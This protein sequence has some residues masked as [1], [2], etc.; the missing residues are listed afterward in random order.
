M[1]T[2]STSTTELDRPRFFIDGRWANPVG[3]EVYT[4]LEAATGEPLGRAALGSPADIDAAVTAARRALD[5]GPW[6]RSTPSERAAVMRRFAAALAKRA[7]ATS[8]LVSQENGMPLWL[9]TSFNGAAPVG[10]L[11]RY[12]DWAETVLFEETRASASG[13]TIVR[14]EPV[15]VVGAITPWNYPQALAMNKIAP[16][17]A[18]GCTV[19]L[20]P[21]EIT[22]LDAYVLADAADEAG[23][24]AGV[25]NIVVG[26]RETGAALVAHPGVDTIAFT[27]STAAGRLIAAECGRQIK[28][29]TL[30][31]GGKSAGI[32]LDDADLDVF[33]GGLLAV[34]LRNN[35]QTCT[36][37]SRILAPRSR[38]DEVVDA[39]T[40]FAAEMRIGNPLDAD[41]TCGPM[42][43]SGQ[44]ERVLGYI[45]LGLRSD[46]RLTTGGGRP[47]GFDRGWFV[48]PTVFADVSNHDTIAREEIF[49]P[50][51]VV[52]PYDG[53]DDAIAIANDSSY[54]L[55]GTVWTSDEQRGI[56]VA[57]RVRTG[58]IGVNY[59]ANDAGSPFGGIK[60]S[61]LGRESGREAIDEY[62]EF[63]S[64]YVSS[65]YEPD[66][67]GKA[68]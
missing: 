55:A 8:R 38:Y 6:G 34:S 32:V 39:V 67:E 17:L 54:G 36:A 10:A 62:L 29:V 21:A 13:A 2:G 7:N 53:D 26:G 3:T 52:I 5:S 56:D 9:S 41:T 14:R 48:E 12:A 43:S 31:L 25:I 59:Y 19:V 23:M 66:Q 45:D 44:L 37:S 27:G 57:R 58:T 4:S 28:K 35:G 61:G 33:V 63:K 20:K 65:D 51:L 15:G 50:V 1:I 60:A 24:P 47:A 22:A 30:E 18:A 11:E 64:I 68:R 46:A 49:G 42:A 40:T 16:A